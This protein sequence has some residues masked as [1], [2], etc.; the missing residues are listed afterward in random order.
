M[1]ASKDK[2]KDKKRTSRIGGTPTLCPPTPKNPSNE[3]NPDSAIV[4]GFQVV[5]G[6]G[7]GGEKR[8]YELSKKM[9]NRLC[10]MLFVGS[11]ETKK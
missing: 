8:F 2:V 3:E 11:E 4:V 9:F 7:G 6:W 5:C 1:M 10:L